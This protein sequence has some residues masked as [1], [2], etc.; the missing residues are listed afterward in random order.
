MT[1]IA[2]D[3]HVVRL[4]NIDMG[5]SNSTVVSSSLPDLKGVGKNVPFVGSKIA[6]KLQ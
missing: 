1:A 3:N 5:A 4:R 6:I 2:N